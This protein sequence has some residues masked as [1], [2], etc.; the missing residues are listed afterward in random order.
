MK[1]RWRIRGEMIQISLPHDDAQFCI[2]V[3]RGP[4][5]NMITVNRH[6]GAKS[7]LRTWSG[8]FERSD[9]VPAYRIEQIGLPNLMA[10]NQILHG[11]HDNVR[12][13]NRNRLAEPFAAVSVRGY[14]E[15]GPAILWLRQ[16]HMPDRRVEAGCRLRR[17][18]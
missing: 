12:S 2:L 18:R 16:K 4:D 14:R 3:T 10:A 13:V 6:A 15:Y 17:P 5:Q 11:T 9:Q 8:L 7:I 1:K